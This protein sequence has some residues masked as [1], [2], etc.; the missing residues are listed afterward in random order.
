MII[1]GCSVAPR[2][3]VDVSLIPDDCANRNAII[4]W[5]DKASQHPR[6]YL[7]NKEEHERHRSEAKARIWHL[8][9]VCQP[10]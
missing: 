2:Q 4:A 6:L 7:Q 3:P 1:M 9:Y 10:V 5:L 8:R